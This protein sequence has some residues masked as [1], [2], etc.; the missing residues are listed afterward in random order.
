MSIYFVSLIGSY[1]IAIAAIA[2]IARFREIDPVYRPFVYVCWLALINE[3]I[4]TVT[5][6]VYKNNA[7]NLN[8][9]VL[10]ECFLFLFQFYKWGEFENRKFGWRVLCAFLLLT[11]FLDNFILN[12]FLTINSLFRI[13]YSFVVVFLAINLINKIMVERR[14]R[15]IN[16]ARFLI[17][18]GIIIFYSYKAFFETFYLLKLNFSND[19]YN[20]IH[21][22]L[23]AANVLVNF[24]FAVAIFR[25]PKQQNFVLPF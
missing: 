1:S 24:L 15:L 9:Y 8:I 4:S 7:V 23:E 14:N 13:V 20:Y 25:I 21:L 16:D 10:L 5:T 3:S 19:F 18:T 11:W 6:L 2:G 17:C 12:S 22:I